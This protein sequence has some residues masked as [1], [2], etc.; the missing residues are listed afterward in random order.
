[1][2]VI[3]F[4]YFA[5]VD[6]RKSPG[7][8]KKIDNTVV[9]A[10]NI[11]LKATGYCYP[12]NLNGVISFFKALVMCKSQFAMIRYSD[13]IS[14][15]VFLVMI[16]LRLKG[17]KIIVD[18]PT[19]R[20][21]GL[22]EIE[23]AVE[24]KTFRFFRKYLMIITAGWIFYPAHRVVQYADE[25]S[26]FEF[27]VRKK[28]LKIGNGI[29][30]DNNLTMV[31]STWPNSSNELKLIGVAQLASWHGYDRLINALASIEIKK[32]PYNIIF[33][34]VGDGNERSGLE[35]LVEKLKLQNQVFFTGMLSGQGLSDAFSDKHIGIA[36]LGLYRIGLDESSVLKTREYIA[37]GLPVIGVGSDPDFYFDSP[38]RLIVPNDDG[39]DE[40]IDVICSFGGRKLPLPEDVRCFAVERLSLEVK[41]RQIISLE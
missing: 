30:I 7:V 13:L 16:F 1:M 3:S 17:V 24:S 11:G 8:S 23:I 14:P 26:W 12:T 29:L 15:L 27:G 2:K 38:Y 41:L 28:T 6:V 25:H 20:I 22:K 18:V 19:P 35:R 37:R 5:L 36:S 33:T 40:L 31:Q 21:V 4:N 9:A 10:N 32:L 34:I 39:V